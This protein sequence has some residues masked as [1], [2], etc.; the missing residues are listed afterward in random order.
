MSVFKRIYLQVWNTVELEV[1]FQIS[2]KSMLDSFLF[3]SEL[4]HW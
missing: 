2:S 4:F 1:L 3:K